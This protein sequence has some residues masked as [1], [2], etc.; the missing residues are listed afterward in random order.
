MRVETL[1]DT[2][3]KWIVNV[4]LRGEVTPYIYL[5][6]SGCC[7]PFYSYFSLC[8]LSHAQLQRHQCAQQQNLLQ[9]SAGAL[10]SAR[11]CRTAHIALFDQDP[12]W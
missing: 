5:I 10:P 3:G 8:R 7:T 1:T 11:W 2:T 12:P 9:H 6:I 4:A